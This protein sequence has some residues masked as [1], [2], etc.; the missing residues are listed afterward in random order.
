MAEGFASHP[1]FDLRTSTWFTDGRRREE[2]AGHA[3][4]VRALTV[5]PPGFA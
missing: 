5:D 3:A 1:S 4:C 2:D